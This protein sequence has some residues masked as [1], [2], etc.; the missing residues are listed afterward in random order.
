MALYP[1]NKE[2]YELQVDLPDS[3]IP[4]ERMI[5]GQYAITPILAD[6]T[7][8]YGILDDQATSTE[9]TTVTTGFLA[10]PPGAAFILSVTPGGTTADV[11]AGDVT[12]VGTDVDG[13]EQTDTITF[14]ANASTAGYT[15]KAFKTVTSI[16]WIAQ[17]GAGATFDVGWVIGGYKRGVATSASATTE[18][19]SFYNQ[20]DVPRTVVITPGG[21]TADVPAGAVTIVGTDIGDNA[22]T[23]TITFAA[24]A[25][26][27]GTSAA[28]FKTITSV[29]FP[30]QDGAGATYDIGWGDA[31]GLPCIPATTEH[32]FLATFD[33]SADAG[34]VT[35]GATAAKSLY[36]AA[37]TFT[38]A[39]EL[40]LNILG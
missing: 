40:L 1:L 35:K 9:V 3:I 10:Q 39:K 28:A 15:T 18:V 13:D 12:I 32:V 5:V 6:A 21:T 27:A 19:T 31:I 20:P 26:S 38:G 29:T 25:S 37:G 14:L 7:D 8:A 34:S 11:A 4:L 24:N 36:A 23:D 33:G 30:I 22:L 17:D 16:S 2:D